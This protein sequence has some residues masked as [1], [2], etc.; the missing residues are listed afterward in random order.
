[1]FPSHTVC[2]LVGID[3]PFLILSQLKDLDLGHNE[4]PD[5]FCCKGTV[6]F[7]RK[8]NCLYKACP[9]QS[10]NKKVTEG[11]TGAEYFCEKCNQTFPDFKYRMILMVRVCACACVCPCV[12]S[13]VCIKLIVTLPFCPVIPMLCSLGLTV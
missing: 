2:C 11:S 1:M 8:E 13:E 12:C 7:C 6:A 3:A 4:K 9:S 5:Y 10:C